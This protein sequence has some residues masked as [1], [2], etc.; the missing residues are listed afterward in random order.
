MK[1]SPELKANP[2][3]TSLFLK[4]LIKICFLPI[5]FNENERKI[6]FKWISRKTLSY[7]VIYGGG[8]VVCA[9]CVNFVDT[10]TLRKI[11]EMNVIET[12]TLTSQGS[13]TIMAIT[14]PLILGRQLNNIDINMVWD[15][16]LPF[17]RHGLK[18]IFSSV[19]L[20]LGTNV[21]MFG[22]FL[23]FNY[24]LQSIVKVQSVLLLGN[25]AFLKTLISHE[26]CKVKLILFL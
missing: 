8:Y 23:R 3:R 14:F 9:F 5:T 11:S 26:L 18:T 19:G 16:Q 13:I 22:M 4:F 12:L 2:S 10:D 1:V 7:V 25:S 24:S 17:P 6:R 20:N 15:E 21:G